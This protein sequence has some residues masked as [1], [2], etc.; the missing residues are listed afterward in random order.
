MPQKCRKCRTYR[1]KNQNK[2]KRD[3]CI[4]AFISVLIVVG[5]SVIGTT[6]TQIF[7]MLVVR[8]LIWPYLQS[9]CSHFV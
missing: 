8:I 2:I 1:K 6:S 3:T 5:Y 7:V 4:Y 9:E